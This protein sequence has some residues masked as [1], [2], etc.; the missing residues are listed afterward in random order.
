MHSQAQGTLAELPFCTCGKIR[1][2]LAGRSS[3]PDPLPS[4][5]FPSHYVPFSW[6]VRY[7]ALRAC[8]PLPPLI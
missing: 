6:D 4:L 1:L 2:H 8:R 3:F 7:G 5:H